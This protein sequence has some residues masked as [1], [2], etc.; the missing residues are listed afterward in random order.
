MQHHLIDIDI[1]NGF[2]VIKEAHVHIDGISVIS[3]I[4]GSGISTISKLLYTTFKNAL[5]YDNIVVDIINEKLMPYS[6]ALTQMQMQMSPS[7]ASPRHLYRW[8]L[9]NKEK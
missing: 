7:S 5:Q 2:R 3:G 1:S 9:H 4:N 6:D 8:R